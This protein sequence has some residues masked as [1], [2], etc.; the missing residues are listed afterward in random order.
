VAGV[1]FAPC[2]DDGDNGFAGEVLLT[3]AGLLQS[4]AVGQSGEVVVGKPLGTA[5][6]VRG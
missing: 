4:G 3:I 2:I 5:Q 1:D 6:L